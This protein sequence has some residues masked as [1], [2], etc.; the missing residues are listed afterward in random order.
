MEK[1]FFILKDKYLYRYKKIYF[2]SLIQLQ[3]V[4]NMPVFQILYKYF[5][6]QFN[7]NLNAIAVLPPSNNV[8]VAAIPEAAS[9]YEI[10]NES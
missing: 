8:A 4:R 5:K 2:Q 7:G 10:S 1:V 6:F 9:Y 3:N